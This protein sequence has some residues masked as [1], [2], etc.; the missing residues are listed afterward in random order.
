MWLQIETGQQKHASYLEAR[1]CEPPTVKFHQL[2]HYTQTMNTTQTHIIHIY[3]NKMYKYT[4]IDLW[5][6]K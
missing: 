6:N 4:G 1:I 2:T 3:N 5:T